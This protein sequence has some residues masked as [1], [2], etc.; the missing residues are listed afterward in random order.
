MKDILTR[1]FK[2]RGIKSFE[3][4]DNEEKSTYEQ[5]EKILSKEEFTMED[6]KM[7]CRGQIDTIETK[8]SDLNLDKDKKASFIPYHTV[9]KAILRAIDSPKVAREALEKNL[10]QLIEN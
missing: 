2:K 1:L 7:F 4:L 3:D 10:I 9:Y 6:L 8:W 5:W